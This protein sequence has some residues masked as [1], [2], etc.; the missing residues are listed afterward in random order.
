MA[1]YSTL[2]ESYLHSNFFIFTKSILWATVALLLSFHRYR[3]AHSNIL[4][5]WGRFGYLIDKITENGQ[6]LY[7]YTHAKGG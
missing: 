1:T 6:V 5:V 4:S 2:P 3:G 7:M